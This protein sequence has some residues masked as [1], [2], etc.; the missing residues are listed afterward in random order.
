[1]SI[2]QHAIEADHMYDKTRVEPELCFYDNMV[3]QMDTEL[4]D[5]YEKSNEEIVDICKQVLQEICTNNPEMRRYM[6]SDILYPSVH[7]YT[8][9]DYPAPFHAPE[10]GYVISAKP[11][12]APKVVPSAFSHSSSTIIRMPSEAKSNA[13]EAFFW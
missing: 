13:T 11:L 12:S 7:T 9:D 5:L 1:M 8:Y 2:L 10:D 4:I 3:S 6:N